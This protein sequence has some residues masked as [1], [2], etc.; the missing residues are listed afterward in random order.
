MLTNTYILSLQPGTGTLRIPMSQNDKNETLVLKLRNSAT[1]ADISSGVTA[2]IT[3]K[4]SNGVPF[5]HSVSYSYANGIGTVTVTVYEDMTDVPGAAICEI[6]LSKGSGNNLQRHS[7]ANFILDIEKDPKETPRLFYYDY[8]GKKLLHTEYLFKRTAGTWDETPERESD[9]D[10]SYAFIGWALEPY[11]S[12]VDADAT[13]NVTGNRSVYAVYKAGSKLNYYDYYGINLLYSE[14]VDEG[15]DGT[16]DGEPE[17]DGDN[18]YSYTFL[19]W[20]LEPCSSVANPDSLNTI[21]ENRSIYAAYD[22]HTRSSYYI[23]YYNY[24]GT[25]LLYTESVIAGSDA[26]YNGS[27][28][29]SRD[30]TYTYTFTGWSWSMNSAS[31]DLTATTNVDTDRNV[32]AAYSASLRDSFDVSYYSYDGSTLL[33]TETVHIGGN[34][35]YDGT[36]TRSQDA[37]YTYTF[38]GWSWNTNSET[39]DADATENVTTDRNVYAAY[40]TEIRTYTVTWKNGST[41]IETDT[42][43]PYGTTPTYNGSIPSDG[44]PGYSFAGW[45]PVVEAIIGDTV[46]TARFYSAISDSWSEIF[47]SES[48]GTYST[49]YTIGD[50]KEVEIDGNTYKAQ[51]VDMDVDELADN[52]G[53]HAKITWLL[54]ELYTDRHCMHSITGNNGGW[55]TSEMRSWLNTDILALIPSTVRENIKEVNKT[56]LY[57]GNTSVI[58]DKLWIPSIREVYPRATSFK[59]TIGASYGKVFTNGFSQKKCVIGS[60]AT[61]LWWLR[62]EMNNVNGDYFSVTDRTYTGQTMTEAHSAT[63]EL[64]VCIGFCT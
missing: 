9:K 8:D 19:G 50:Y 53:N 18:K 57:G 64:G 46:Y 35:A 10:H 15:E 42:D 54:K 25:T 47:A 41:V 34:A 28:A 23:Y 62:S 59:E 11:A 26:A 49:K 56:Y 45:T 5:T 60:T 36:P 16:W 7:T 27:P 51:I 48:N 1:S 24:D 61:A 39:P 12:A 21:V 30:A 4:K 14:I 52:S 22:K 17:K 43:V 20:A 29:R 55:A 38:A 13:I 31:S 37:Q 6:T 63:M 58:N 32:Y 33:Y 2:E 44:S 40:T 3:G